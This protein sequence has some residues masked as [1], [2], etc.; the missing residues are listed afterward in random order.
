M[1]VLKRM[2]ETGKVNLAAPAAPSDD[3][4]IGVTPFP[5]DSGAAAP[6]TAPSPFPGRLIR[7][8]S[9]GPDV[10]AVQMRLCDLGIDPGAIDGDFGDNTRNA[11]KLLQALG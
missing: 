3:G 6:T 8:D 9:E 2:M 4:G 7:M 1:A 11:V 5:H 10:T